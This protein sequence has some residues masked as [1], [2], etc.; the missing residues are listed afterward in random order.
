M[1]DP[2]KKKAKK[3]KKV[4]EERRNSSPSPPPSRQEASSSTSA[5]E[6]R[7]R[8]LMLPT[9][10]L[11]P[12]NSGRYVMSPTWAVSSQC[13]TLSS[14]STRNTNSSSSSSSDDSSSLED[15]SVERCIENVQGVG[16]VTNEAAPGLRDNQAL[17][18]VGEIVAQAMRE[19]QIAESVS[20]GQ[21]IGVGAQ[22]RDFTQVEGG[23]RSR[24]IRGD[25][26]G[27]YRQVGSWG[28]RGRDNRPF[29]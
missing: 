16:E 18:R 22:G 1:A 15:K 26:R 21:A 2:N 14:P 10:S 27:G 20:T 29:E 19:A 3:S 13:S 25:D 23:D 6:A 5:T 4:R 7:D 17:A 28:R 8:D 24:E 11:N 12:E 9:P